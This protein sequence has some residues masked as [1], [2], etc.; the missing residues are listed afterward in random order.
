MP[1]SNNR[2]FYWWDQ[3]LQILLFIYAINLSVSV[4]FYEQR[5]YKQKVMC[6]FAVCF[7]I[8]NELWCSKSSILF[9]SGSQYKAHVRNKHVYTIRIS[10]YRCREVGT[11]NSVIITYTRINSKHVCIHLIY[12]LRN[13]SVICKCVMNKYFY[14]IFLFKLFP[15]GGGRVK[16]KH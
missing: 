8:T 11:A 7:R 16:R 4:S 13:Y 15:Y 14:S 6:H 1:L 12:F 5:K 9:T 3:K 10:D 2:R